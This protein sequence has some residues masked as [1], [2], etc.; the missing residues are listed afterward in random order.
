MSETNAIHIADYDYALPDSRIAKYPLAKRDEAKLLV[1]K[2]SDITTSVFARLCSH[3][4]DNTLLVF[5]NTRVIQARI[6]F[7]K[8]TGAAIEIFLLEPA[9]PA[10]YEQMF[11]R[12]GKCAWTCLVG[13]LKKWHSEKLQRPFQ[14]AGQTYTLTAEYKGPQGTA[15]LIEFTWDCD[16]LNYSDIL[17]LAGELPIPPYLN[18][19]SEE[20][21]KTTYQTIYSKVKGSVAAPTAGL[22]FTTRVLEEIDRRGIDHEELTLHVGAGTFR[23]VKSEEIHAHEMHTEYIAVNRKTIEKLLLHGAAATAVGTTT[24]RTLESLYYIG[25][26][27]HDDPSLPLAALHVAQWEPYQRPSTLTASQALQ[28]IL[29]FLDRQKLDVLQTTTQIII[30]PGYRYKIV[31]AMITNFHQPRST[32]LLLVGAFIGDDW[33][34]VYSYALANNYRFLSYGDTCLL[35][36]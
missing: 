3:L 10:D 29:T 27:L 18:R 16:A 12:R 28:E 6:H 4:D 15:H 8:P 24:V 32:L 33:R 35:I 9:I 14:H 31:D 22:H 34:K 5:N 21:D 30:I 19:P 7:R 26:K 11:Q 25:A 2:H 17:D 20:A 23:P 13:N 1:Y 36:P